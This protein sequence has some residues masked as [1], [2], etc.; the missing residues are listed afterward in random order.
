MCTAH[1][2]VMSYTRPNRDTR[3][4]Q[5]AITRLCWPCNI[6]CASNFIKV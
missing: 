6:L 3:T 5:P 4:I 2:G 1:V